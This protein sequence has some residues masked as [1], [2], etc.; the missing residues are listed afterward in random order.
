[1]KTVHGEI[2][3]LMRITRTGALDI[4]Q[5]Y[6]IDFHFVDGYQ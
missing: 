5:I 3:T 4:I 2:S 1:M 6:V